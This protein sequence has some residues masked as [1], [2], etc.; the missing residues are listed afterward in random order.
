[1]ANSAVR[2]EEVTPKSWRLEAPLDVS[3]VDKE[4]DRRLTELRRTTRLPGF[5]RGRVPDRVLIQRVAPNL[6]QH[7]AIREA[8]LEVRRLIAERGL[9]P[10]LPPEVTVRLEPPRIEAT[11]QVF[12]EIDPFDFGALAIERPRVEIDEDDIE[13][14]LMRL[15]EKY[16]A[17]H[18]LGEVPLREALRDSMESELGEAIRL[19]LADRVEAALVTA[20]SPVELPTRLLERVEA[21]T[22]STDP[23]GTTARQTLV[24]TLAVAQAARQLEVRP[25]P[26]TLWEETERIAGRSDEPQRTLDE[27]WADPMWI[28]EIESD[29][30]RQ[31]VA[32]EVLAK[33]RVTEVRL[34]FTQFAE[35]RRCK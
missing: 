16:V 17:G 8:Q 34:N 19:E 29:L 4:F 25:D 27:M 6:R 21:E 13:Q 9:A 24:A 31:R 10:A 7:L 15:D 14:M 2:F 20:L 23:E 1:M 3:L 11:F 26:A 32:R 35:L 12:P 28:Q 30:L 18:P 22:Q 33:A 5:R